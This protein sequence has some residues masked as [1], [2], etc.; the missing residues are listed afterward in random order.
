MPASS[1]QPSGSTSS[2]TI[3]P[4]AEFVFTEWDRRTRARD[5]EALLELYA[6]D[7]VFESPLAPRILGRQ[8]GVLRGKEALARLFEEGGRRRPNELV[9]RQRDGPY[10][11]DGRHLSW[12]YLRAAPDGA[13]MT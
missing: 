6:E 7:V 1:P 8:S 5:V 3:N 13:Q 9:R 4:D 2:A 10:L 12:E 11:W